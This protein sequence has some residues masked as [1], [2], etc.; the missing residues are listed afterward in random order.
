MDGQA[1]ITVSAAV[2][3]ATQLTKWSGLPPARAPFVVCALSLL[4]VLLWIFSQGEPRRELTFDY[5]AAWIAI[6]TSA[7]GV[8]GFTRAASS[9]LAASSSA[10]DRG[11][12]SGDESS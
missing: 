9:S 8:Y 6:A 1:I 5:F 11:A 3:A 4:G 7:A 10:R 12:S 2:V